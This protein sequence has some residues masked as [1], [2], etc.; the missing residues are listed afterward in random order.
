MNRWLIAILSLCVLVAGLLFF[1]PDLVAWQLNKSLGQ[2]PLASLI[3]DAARQ[4]TTAFLAMEKPLV[5]ADI[6]ASVTEKAVVQEI[7]SVVS[8][9]ELPDGWKVTLLD[10]PS[11][12]SLPNALRLRAKTQVENAG[13]GSATV[14][15]S[16][17]AI[18]HIEA[19]AVVF[20]LAVSSA[21][22]DR[23]S[24]R[25]FRL[26]WPLPDVITETVQ[27]SLSTINARLK[28]VK[29]ET[30]APSLPGGGELAGAVLLTRDSVAVLLGKR[31]ASPRPALKGTYEQ[32]FVAAARDIMPDYKPGAGLI[33]VD[34]SENTL[35][36]TSEA[37]RA[38]SIAINLQHTEGILGTDHTT[39][40]AAVTSDLSQVMLATIAADY[41]EQQMKLI[42]QDALAKVSAPGVALI[43]KPEDIHVKTVE[44]ALEAN[45]DGSAKFL[46][47]AI[48]I[49][50]T[51]TAWCVLDPSLNGLRARYAVRDFR[52]QRLLAKWNEVDASLKIEN[53]NALAA[54]V[55]K[56]VKELPETTI[57]IPTIALKLPK[58]TGDVRIEFE[59][60]EPE[61]QLFGRTV[62]LS[63][64]R[65]MVMTIPSVP[66]GSLAQQVRQL[67][68]IT[69]D[70]GPRP[71]AASDFQR[72]K[73]LF[74]LSYK[75]IF[76]SDPPDQLNVGIRGEGLARL[77]NAAWGFAR[78]SV[79]AELHGRSDIPRS[80]IQAIPGSAS[81]SSM[82]PSTDSCGEIG[83]CK[84]QVCST[85]VDHICNTICPGG[86]LNPLCHI[87]CHDADQQLCHE[88]DDNNCINRVRQC[89]TSVGTCAATWSSG[90][91][92]ACEAAMK[93]IDVTGFRGLAIISGN[94]TYAG[95]GQTISAITLNVAPDLQSVSLGGTASAR[96]QAGA[97]INIV[98][99]DFGNL[100]LC[101]SGTLS[102]NFVIGAPTQ[103]ITIPA[104]IS[105]SGG[106]G[107]PLKATLSPS[108]V[109]VQ[110]AAPEAPIVTLAKSNPGLLSCALGQ[111]V[112]GLAIAV[113]PHVTADLIASAIRKALPN[114]TGAAVAAVLDGK[115]LLKV[116]IKPIDLEV[117][118][119]TFP[120]NGQDV[121][122]SPRLTA[123][124]SFI[125]ARPSK[126]IVQPRT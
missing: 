53:A 35:P 84:I 114:D 81:C 58:Q 66:N 7:T 44:G 85:V 46:Q 29:L 20:A 8:G 57:K 26:P 118:P 120:L 67:Q 45:V 17:D 14:D 101:P 97:S 123:A 51:L 80:E 16:I 93:G 109:E 71:P 49:D 23:V 72:L 5:L 102:S 76:A 117:P 75:K 95:A 59:K 52:I 125:Y 1:L 103:T 31:A 18:P 39:D 89:A 13:I 4:N 91:R 96:A 38:S 65:V 56:T 47:G 68:W 78:P 6:P 30:K 83:K 61:I 74:Q 124:G 108:S 24:V 64:D 92:V 36:N 90:L 100:L 62:L 11:A 122:L 55:L 113:A 34:Q 15:V 115:Y 98:W 104:A 70:V 25:G 63:P 22:A 79:V 32:D 37:L 94:L 12:S 88:D 43:V 110:V 116:D 105:W 60:N 111:A 3:D 121:Q 21:S 40:P 87:A 126:E 99:T 50:F 107:P 33:A 119:L 28:P 42:L 27:K 69:S 106:N 82:C 54:L 77:M 86:W 9:L 41:L 2:R 112:V 10:T 19:R 73:A 48:T